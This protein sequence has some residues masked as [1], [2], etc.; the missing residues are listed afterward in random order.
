MAKG[1]QKTKST[2]TQ[3]LTGSSLGMQNDIYGTARAAANGYTAAGVDPNS[4]A[5]AGAYG[6]MMG[7]GQNGL[8]ALGGDASAMGRLM[9]PYTGEVIDAV[10]SDF[11]RARGGVS[12][13]VNDQA[14][15]ANAFGGSRHGVAEGMAQGELERN[16]MST[17]AGLR[18]SGYRDAQG[19]AGQL[20]NMGLAGAQGGAQMG[21]YMRNVEQERLNPGVAKLGLL[22]AGMAG[23]GTMSGQQTTMT[24]QPGTSALQNI[25]GLASLGAG[26]FG[27]PLGAAGAK[28]A[29]GLFGRKPAVGPSNYN[30]ATFW[31][32]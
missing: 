23:G 12:A 2:Q 9:N 17:I 1:G 29:G 4:A 22:N 31:G 28:L 27:G 11:D 20:A 8:A 18:Q 19:V 13:N 14:T 24:Q 16:R 7:A 6:G 32:D 10:N 21:E 15:R 30:P 5:A 26:I 3:G 25:G